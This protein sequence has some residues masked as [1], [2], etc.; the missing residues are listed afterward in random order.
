MIGEFEGL[1]GNEIVSQHSIERWQ[2]IPKTPDQMRFM[3]SSSLLLVEVSGG[4]FIT[5]STAGGGN[6]VHQGL[7]GEN[8]GWLTH[9]FP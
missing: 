3:I 8:N 1:F 6:Y 9:E 7:R 5:A 2:A 4:P